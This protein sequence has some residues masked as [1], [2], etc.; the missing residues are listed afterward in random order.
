MGFKAKQSFYAGV[1]KVDQ[2]EPEMNFFIGFCM[3][4]IG[5]FGL[6]Y[7]LVDGPVVMMYKVGLAFVCVTIF[8]TG[9]KNAKYWLENIRNKK[10]K[11]AVSEVQK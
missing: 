3:M 1:A 10:E 4:L 6:V 7:A 5:G 9:F 8:F 11:T 2:V